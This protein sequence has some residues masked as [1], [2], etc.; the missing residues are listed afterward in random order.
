MT[1]EQKHSVTMLR[2]SG[3]SYAKIASELNISE[4][5]VKT[6]CRRNALTTKAMQSTRICKNCGAPMSIKFKGKEKLF[7]SD[8]CRI[9]WHRNQSGY[10]NTRYSLVCE[11]CGKL[12][13][14]CG[15][16][17]QR[18]CSHSCYIAARFGK[19]GEYHG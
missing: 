17:N 16:K 15:N 10:I 11:H 9:A 4:N 14:S 12:F 19:G 6:F 2:K 7:C 8:R 5:T 1:N 3:V 18:Y 13:E